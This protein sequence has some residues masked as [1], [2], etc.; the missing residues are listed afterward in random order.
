LFLPQDY[1]LKQICVV[2][3]ADG[4]TPNPEKLL[5]TLSPGNSW[6]KKTFVLLGGGGTRL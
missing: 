6:F 2:T 4:N 5:L 1:F 3:R